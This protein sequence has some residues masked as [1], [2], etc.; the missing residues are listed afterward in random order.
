MLCAKGSDTK[1]FWL[2]QGLHGLFPNMALAMSLD[3][4]QAFK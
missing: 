4:L 2:D 3:S 1:G